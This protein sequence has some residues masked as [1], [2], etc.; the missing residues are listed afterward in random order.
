MNVDWH[1]PN[2]ARVA[3]LPN[4]VADGPHE[5]P[6]E[7]DAAAGPDDH[8]PD[9]EYYRITMAGLRITVGLTRLTVDFRTKRLIRTESPAVLRMA[10]LSVL[11]I[12][13]DD[14]N[15]IRL[16]YAATAPQW[17][18]E[19][20]QETPDLPAMLLIGLCLFPIGFITS[21]SVAM[22]WILTV[23]WLAFLRYVEHLLS[24][25]NLGI[26]VGGD[27]DHQQAVDLG[28]LGAA[29]QGQDIFHVF[30]GPSVQGNHL[31]DEDVEGLEEDMNEMN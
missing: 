6:M 30:V 15:P 22:F 4:G 17:L 12:Y 20:L 7:N 26:T 19:L 21:I 10:Q 18:R 13:N 1:V 28:D 11:L 31:S 8:D 25:L 27:L 5:V 14:A 9:E 24:G 16:F 2:G 23:P 3:H 29:W